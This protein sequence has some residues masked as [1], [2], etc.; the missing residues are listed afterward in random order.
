VSLTIWSWNVNGLRAIL[1]KDFLKVI[2]AE[3]PDILGLQETK[4]QADQIPDDFSLLTGYRQ[5]WSHAERKGYSGT[6]L[7]TKPVPL[8]IAYGFDTP[9]Y[10]T[11]GRI[12]LAEYP[13]FWLFNI[14]FPNGQM[15]E[16]R[17]NYKLGFYDRCL[18]VMEDKRQT[19]KMVLVSGDFNT[20]HQPIDLAHP[21]ANET[22]S[23]F[24]PIERKWL[25]GI[26]ALGWVDTFRVY[27]S[28]PEQYSWWTYIGNARA[29]N[30]GWRIDY[31]FVNREHLPRI[32]QAGIRQDIYGSDHCP[33]YVVI[34]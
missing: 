10:D 18:Q 26:I 1:N 24:L 6:C 15:N 33:V 29:R 3:Q 19:G 27:D 12:I 21:K 32:R 13:D 14:Y 2:Q 34:V 5:Y 23:G 25:D 4:L 9:Q 31:F 16:D 17:L 30:T 22:T 7:L 28:A 11:E 20:A 8:Q